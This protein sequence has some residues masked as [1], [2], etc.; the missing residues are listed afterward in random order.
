MYEKVIHDVNKQG[1]I[2]RLIQ[3]CWHALAYFCLNGQGSEF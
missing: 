1:H 2:K 3:G